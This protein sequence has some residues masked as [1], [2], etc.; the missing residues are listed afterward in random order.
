MQPQVQAPVPEGPEV[1]VAAREPLFSELKKLW[2]HRA[3]LTTLT[4]NDLRYRYMGSSIGFFWAVINPLVELMTY[5][6]VFHV[7]MGVKFSE[8]GGTVHYSLF[9]FCGMV[10]WFALA[11]GCQ[12]ATWSI[13]ENAQLI[14]K[15]NFPAAVLPA[16]VVFSA[17]VN[18][19]IRFGVLALAIIFLGTG[20]GTGLS[21]LVVTLP[22]FVAI[23]AVFV[24][25]LS[26]FLATAHVYFRDTGHW[27]NA[28]FLAWMFITPIFYPPHAYPQEFQILL[29]LNPMAHFVGIYQEIM[30]NARMPAIRQILFAVMY[31]GSSLVIGYS[32]FVHHRKRFADLV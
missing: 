23:Q 21:P 3:L 4:V 13:R 17:I 10:G 27:V 30:L 26:F 15:V 22:I 7:L 32:V 2:T 12:R 25:G 28:L 29:Q 18:Q 6:F 8:R 1:A 19:Y 16:S 5:T 9:L 31:A 11:E 24:L 20:A 14:K